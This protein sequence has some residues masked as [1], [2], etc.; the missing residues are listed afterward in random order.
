M[1]LKM[2]FA[3]LAALPLI[4]SAQDVEALRAAYHDAKQRAHVASHAAADECEASMRVPVC[5]A[6]A[7][8]ALVERRAMVAAASDYC[9]AVLPPSECDPWLSKLRED[10]D[11]IEALANMAE[12]KGVPS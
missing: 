3:A 11:A 5:V 1:K 4:A 6:A 7:R 2:L 9:A 8:R 12:G 10:D